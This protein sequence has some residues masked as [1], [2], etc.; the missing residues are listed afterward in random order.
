MVASSSNSDPWGRQ[1]MAQ[2]Q[3]QSQ[4]PFQ[5]QSQPQ[6]AASQQGNQMAGQESYGQPPAF[7]QQ[8]PPQKFMMVQQPPSQYQQQTQRLY[9]PPQQL[10]SMQQQSRPAVAPPTTGT[11]ELTEE[12]RA[13]YQPLQSAAHYVAQSMDSDDRAL[14][15]LDDYLSEMFAADRSP[16]STDGGFSHQQP[17]SFQRN[18][19]Y[20]TQIFLNRSRERKDM[21]SPLHS[22]MHFVSRVFNADT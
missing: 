8:I 15:K 4:L 19:I 3:S 2:S 6:M 21:S 9:Q 14:S 12:E 16:Q 5:H 13:L 1:Q 11:E 7:S 22:L 18:M 20:Q 17:S 10:S